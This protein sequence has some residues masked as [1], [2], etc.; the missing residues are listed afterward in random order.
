[1]EGPP[2]K[3]SFRPLSLDDSEIIADIAESAFGPSR[4]RAS[5]IRRY[6]SLEPNY[7]LM[8]LF[9]GRPAGVVGA[10]DY[11]PFAY[12]GMMT[13]RKDLQ[14]I[15][16]GAA[17]FR[18]ELEW[19]HDEGV[20]F[21]RLDATEEGLPIYA[22]NGFQVV[23][24]AAMLQR[25]HHARFLNPPG[26]IQR[27]T[28]ADSE[29]LAAFDTPLFGADRTQLF[30]ALLE[31]FPDRAFASYD[32]ARR[33]TGFLFA[34]HRRLGPWVA[35]NPVDARSLL[36]AAMTLTFQ[37]PPVAVAPRCNAAAFRLLEE[38]GFIWKRESVHMHRGA[39]TVPGD[40]TTIYG[41]TSFAIG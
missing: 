13:V 14:R 24:R 19:L 38:L 40:R 6:L 18:R 8:A 11:G 26:R 37:G 3:V 15:G 39:V 22:R 16:I 23:D 34:Q 4:H 1:M 31:D 5:E 9:Q 10:T 21:L 32:D 29:E 17:L 35:R 28:E 33:M 36:E 20:F 7:W 2:A 27:L 41:L 12:L 30:R 25:S